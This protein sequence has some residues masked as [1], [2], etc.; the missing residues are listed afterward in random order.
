MTVKKGGKIDSLVEILLVFFRVVGEPS[1]RDNFRLYLLTHERTLFPF[2]VV[3][4]GLVCGLAIYLST[5]KPLIG[6]FGPPAISGGI[7]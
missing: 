7:R 6:D 2:M 5:L 1:M 3:G 4:V